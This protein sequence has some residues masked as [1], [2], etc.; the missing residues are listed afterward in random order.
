MRPND[1][2]LKNA[3][4]EPFSNFTYSLNDYSDENH[5]I[6]VNIKQSGIESADLNLPFSME[7]DTNLKLTKKQANKVFQR[8]YNFSLNDDE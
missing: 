5:Y 7:I 4:I 2:Y 1:K 3:V 6:Y 8:V